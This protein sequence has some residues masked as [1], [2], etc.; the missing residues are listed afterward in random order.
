MSMNLYELLTNVF[1]KPDL[2]S[3]CK[4]KSLCSHNA[5]DTDI[6]VGDAE[7]INQILQASQDMSAG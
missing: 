7:G 5:S 2:T 3:M 6:L 4:K 1:L